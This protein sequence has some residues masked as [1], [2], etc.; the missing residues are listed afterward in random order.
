MILTPTRLFYPGFRAKTSAHLARFFSANASIRYE[1]VLVSRPDPAVALITLNRPKALNAL[2]AAHFSDISMALKEADE[3][4]DIG[5]MVLTGSDKAFAAGADIKE[6]KD[7]TFSEA[8][9]SNFLSNWEVISKL[10]KPVIAAVSG[11]ALGGGLELALQ[12][13][14]L[15]A[16]PSAKLGQPEIN[17]GVIPGGGGTQRLA[18]LIG[19]S[20]A[21]EMILTGRIVDAEEAER[22]G[23]VN[24]VVRDENGVVEAAIKVAQDIAGKSRV[25]A[26]AGK[27]AVNAAFELS[28]AEGLRLERRLFHSLFAT[29]DQKE[30][31][32]A[33]AEKRQPQWTH[34]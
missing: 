6:M 11:Y 34:S 17:L 9:M 10:R 5:A 12:A 19:K 1:N 25:A 22:W 30:G 29:K 26:A 3:N 7:K 14:I 31:M 21:M 8:Y 16:A 15:L 4:P 2:N 18:R 13:D 20:R 27:E 33:F 23:L 32:M 28:L 24:R